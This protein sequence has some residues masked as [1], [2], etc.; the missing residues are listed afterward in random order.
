MMESQKL[1]KGNGVMPGL[2]SHFCIFK[3]FWIQTCAGMTIIGL[4]ATLS[5]ISEEQYLTKR[6]Q[7]VHMNYFKKRLG[8]KKAPTFKSYFL[9]L[10]PR[11]FDRGELS[12]IA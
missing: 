1:K 9:D 11:P 8:L 10:T 5:K 2:I 3:Y 12:A 6:E 7:A 4:S